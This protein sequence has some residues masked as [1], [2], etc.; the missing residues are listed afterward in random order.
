M[1]ARLPNIYATWRAAFA[2]ANGEGADV[3]GVGA[4][5][6]NGVQTK[7]INVKP[8][9]QTTPHSTAVYLNFAASN[10]NSIYSGSTRVLP[11][12]RRCIM[13]IHY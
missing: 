7:T 1:D 11:A 8:S 3:S 2:T 5:S 9:G 10:Y 12:S 4:A 13:C 6:I